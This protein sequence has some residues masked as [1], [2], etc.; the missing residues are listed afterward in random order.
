MQLLDLA[1]KLKGVQR[2][3]VC[4]DDRATLTVLGDHLSADRF[5]VLAAADGSDA[6]SLCELARPN[7]LILALSLPDGGG[8]KVL[9]EIRGST[10][11]SL[12]DPDLPV[13]VISH[14][15][16]ERDRIRSLEHGADDYLIRPFSYSELVARIGAVLQRRTRQMESPLKVE[17]GLEIDRHRR[18]ARVHGRPVYLSVKEFSL[19]LVLA[20][21]PTRVFS[22][23]ELLREVWGYRAIGHTRT[24][25]AHADRLRGKLD[26]DG[27]RFVVNCWGVGYR[28]ASVF[29][30]DGADRHERQVG[31]ES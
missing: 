28:L 31:L 21:E 3:V 6:L 1:N 22:K 17:G 8:L 29:D 10:P 27:G 11:D 16:N 4:E 20:T 15:G 13:I 14:R 2:I 19:L 30:P 9:K 5:D 26:P 12:L 25:E 24:L 23:E 7:L 18:T